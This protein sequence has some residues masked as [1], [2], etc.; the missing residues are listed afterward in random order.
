MRLPKVC[1]LVISCIVAHVLIS[2]RPARGGFSTLVVQDA[3]QPSTNPQ[4]DFEEVLGG[5]KTG[6]LTGVFQNGFP[7]PRSVNVNYDVIS[8]TTTIHFQGGQIGSSST[9]YYAFG[10]AIN[11]IV[12]SPGGP[13]INPGS[14]DGYW[15]PG[16][17]IPGHVPEQNISSQY[18][19]ASNQ[20]VITIANDPGTFSL[21]DV[22]YLVTNDPFDISS[23][24]RATL[25]PG[26]FIASG[27]PDGTTLGPGGST[28]F[29]IS[30]VNPGQYVT[31]FSDA[32]WSGDS[33]SNFYQ[34]P[35]G[36]WFEFQ[37]VPEPASWVLAL[38]GIG[39]IL[40]GR[41]KRISLAQTRAWI[42]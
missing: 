34:Q 38:I 25:P 6:L 29:T 35:S 33:S 20:A 26:A 2:G 24:N 19:T 18:M 39:G 30:G 14:I 31:V 37:A 41:V 4:D 21:S 3:T 8:N 12:G 22:G 9:T 40:A 23:L 17:T 10:Y 28:S 5:N 27:V 7:G 13:V 1:A 11:A 32:Q 42:H 16:V 15:T 36:T